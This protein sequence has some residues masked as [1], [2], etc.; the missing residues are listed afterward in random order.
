MPTLTWQTRGRGIQ[1]AA[2]A[3]YRL[4]EAAPELD[5]GG[6]R[7]AVPLAGGGAGIGRRR[8]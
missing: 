7:C 8:R 3:P 5:G 4:L 1:A 6:D 2:D